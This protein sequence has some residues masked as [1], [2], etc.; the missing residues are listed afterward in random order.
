[1]PAG[2][3]SQRFRRRS[4]PW[5]LATAACGGLGSAHD[6]RPRRALLHHSHSWASP[7]LRRRFRVTRPTTDSGWG[8]IVHCTSPDLVAA[9]GYAAKPYRLGGGSMKVNHLRRRE[10]ITLLG[11]AAAC[12]VAGRAQQAGRVRRVGVLTMGAEVSP[13]EAAF[14]QALADL[15]YVVGQ[16]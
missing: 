6:C 4:P 8:P 3:L 9:L 5:Y 10:F 14:Q 2:I 16:N 7:I 13:F 15:G 11:G 1:M 12:P